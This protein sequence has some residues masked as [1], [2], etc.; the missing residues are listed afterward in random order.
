MLVLV[1]YSD[2]HTG[3]DPVWLFQCF[4]ET[5]QSSLK[6]ATQP[7]MLKLVTGGKNN[8]QSTWSFIFRHCQ[9]L[10]PHIIQCFAEQ[11]AALIESTGIV[12]QQYVQST[13]ISIGSGHTAHTRCN[14]CG[15]L[16]M[17]YM[18]TIW[19]INTPAHTTL[20]TVSSLTRLFEND[21]LL[22]IVV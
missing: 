21:K 6:Y 2:G 5:C 3:V 4:T 1:Y 20:L 15:Y 10:C 22:V 9:C 17:V 8:L 11:Y 19:K 12:F 7:S 16:I 14:T 18:C 13:G